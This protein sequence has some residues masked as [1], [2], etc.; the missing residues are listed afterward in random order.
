MSMLSFRYAGITVGSSMSYGMYCS[1]ARTPNRPS[2]SRRRACARGLA[3]WNATNAV[4]QQRKA[5][6]VVGV[7]NEWIVRA[8][9][10][11]NGVV[12]LQWRLVRMHV[13]KRA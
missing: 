11:A 9:R 2:N 7:H 12:Y 8:N 6:E 5:I 13:K 4:G 1:G 3:C 10:S